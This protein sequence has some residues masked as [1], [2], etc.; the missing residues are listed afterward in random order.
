M[1]TRRQIDIA[2]WINEEIAR[3]NPYDKSTQ[4]RLCLLYSI[5]V[6][7]GFV[8]RHISEMAL[9]SD[10]FKGTIQAIKEKRKL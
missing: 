3:I 7:E 9:S 8:A 4:S 2:N 6:L 10:D 1:P 5:G